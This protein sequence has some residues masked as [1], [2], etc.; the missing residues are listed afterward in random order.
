MRKPES[1]STRADEERIREKLREKLRKSQE[2]LIGDA[3]KPL[4]EQSRKPGESEPTG[5][6]FTPR[7]G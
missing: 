4:D 2:K 1:S 6:A 5:A 3:D 7:T